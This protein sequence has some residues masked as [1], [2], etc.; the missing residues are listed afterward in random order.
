MS[1][2]SGIFNLLYNS[3]L[4]KNA[5]KPLQTGM[6]KWTDSLMET[7]NKNNNNNNKRKLLKIQI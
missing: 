1:L 6:K 3:I 2:C 7:K 5:C 4:N